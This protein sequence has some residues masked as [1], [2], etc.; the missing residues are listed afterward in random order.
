MKGN[1]LSANSIYD[2]ICDLNYEAKEVLAHSVNTSKRYEKFQ[3]KQR[4][5]ENEV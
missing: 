5:L 3:A 2:D 1:T 4:E